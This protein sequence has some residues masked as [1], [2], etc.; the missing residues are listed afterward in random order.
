MKQK[1]E[2]LGYDIRRL[3]VDDGVFNAKIVDRQSGGIVKANF[4]HATGELVRAKLA[5]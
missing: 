3:K 4:D 5:S 2:A 1:I